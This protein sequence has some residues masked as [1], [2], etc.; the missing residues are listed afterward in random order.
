MVFQASENV[1]YEFFKRFG[2]VKSVRYSFPRAGNYVLK[3][4]QY[5]HI[6]FDDAKVAS[7]LIKQG[8]IKM[9]HMG[10]GVKPK[11][12]SNNSGAE[13]MEI[14]AIEEAI[15]S[16]QLAVPDNLPDTS[17]DDLL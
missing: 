16:L 5:I 8:Q 13:Q 1:A 3:R 10:L 2:G 15:S 6:Q 9:H 12:D 14:L 17:I 4:F 7:D 11:N